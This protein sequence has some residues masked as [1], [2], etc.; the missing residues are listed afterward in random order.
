[1]MTRSKSSL[2]A[3]TF[4]AT[5]ALLASPAWAQ[6][7]PVTEETDV[8]TTE[9]ESDA[10]IVVTGTIIQNP[11]LTSS[12]PVNAVSENELELQQA[13]LAE[14]VLRE[15]PGI[16][17]S[18]GQASN[19]GNGGNSFVDLRGLGPNRNVVLLDGRRVVP[20]T[21]SGLFDLNNIP[22]ALI[23][24]V[25]VLTGGASTT[26]GAD[27]VSGVV[28]F[29]TRRDFAGIDIN[30]SE[31]IS[32]RGDGNIFRADVLIGASFD[33]GRG[34][35]VINTGYQEADPI[36]PGARDFGAFAISSTT[37]GPG[38]SGT[39]VPSRFTLGTIGTR[40]V[41]ATGDAFLP[42]AA[43]TAFNFNPYNVYQVPFERYNVY[44]AGNYQI[45]DAIEV[46]GRGLFSQNTVDTIIAPSG[47]FGIAVT[48]P[49]NNPFLTPALRNQFCAGNGIPQAACD[50]AANP[51]LRPGDA[52]YRQVA[53]GLFRRAVEVG[54]RISNYVNSVFD[55]MVGATGG[56][57]DTID[58]DLFGAYGESRQV[59]EIQNYLL[60]SRTR[61]SIAA[62]RNA[63]GQPVCFQPA[64]Q[65][66]VGTFPTPASCVPINW[67]GPAG[68]ATWT[69]A[70]IDFLSD[71]SVVRTNVAL[72]QARGTVSGDFGWPMPWAEDPVAFA[73]GG[74]YR[75]Y[76]AQQAS[77]SLA[78]SGDLGGAGG[79][80]PNIDGGFHVYEAFAELIVPVIQDRPF[81][82]EVQFE[83]GIRY[84]DYTIDAPGS[85]TFNTT[86]WKV[87][88]HWEPVRG[89]RFRGNY[90]HAVRAPNIAELFAPV[91]T[92]L[93]GL[94]DDPCARLND[95]G[96]PTGRG[97]L[98]GELLAVCLAQGAPAGVVQ[99]ISQPIAGQALQTTGGNINL[100]PETA[101]TWTVGLIFQPD[102]IPGLSLSVDYYNIE[103]TGAVSA[104][105]PNDVI[106]ACFGS[107][108]ANP[109]T[110]V[111]PPAGASTSPACTGIRRDPL[112]GTLSGDPATST[113]LPRQASNLGRI[114]T[115]GVD[116]TL[117]YSRDLGFAG[118]D[119]AAVLNWTDE[120]IFQATPVSAPRE[121]VGFYSVN[122]QQPIF[123]WQWNV[124]TTFSFDD[125]D[126]S[127]L[128]RHFD[129]VRYEPGI[130]TLFAGTLPASTGR[131]AGQ[132]VDFNRIEA[133]DYFDLAI[134]IPVDE[135][136][137]LNLGVQNIF[138]T[139][140]PIVGGEAGDLP[141]SNGNVFPS[142]YDA[143][144][145]FYTA[146]AR[147][148]F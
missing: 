15:V 21:L 50:A 97:P 8:A 68:N 69:P 106:V 39:A 132:Q 20:A 47:S 58:W 81:F 144:G 62:G 135:H 67:F 121:C 23:Q 65:P 64:P 46:Y 52:A 10:P 71:T 93:I 118:L 86:T 6:V 16:V 116:F 32:E 25:D 140:P 3:S 9:E 112:T 84:S 45:S 136:F 27:A 48:L 99:Q 42:T 18:V 111:T 54:P 119:I 26:Y 17:P 120:L 4:F 19:N 130:G 28:N 131:V 122:C 57:T 31:Q 109:A 55:Y 70:A 63:A 128:W 22:L 14:E 94:T 85:P 91:N 141:F 102:F 134:R 37:G 100:L 115:S 44:T 117:N 49:L 89:L 33:D 77:D 145:R 38:G 24:R 88:G 56:I 123:E 124:R 83:G 146:G 29:I 92:G 125:I 12:S 13:N 138:D 78:Q 142:T 143:R 87:G 40:Q 104:P 35:V 137:T 101:N 148:R 72:A 108:A 95:Q 103:I 60:N 79:A 98:T 66:G 80:S 110:L 96:A 107:A 61:A 36:Y 90:S 129:N 127:L 113:G 43:F 82:N 76:D 133:H 30:L 147:I 7:E 51:L 34:T 59:T 11:N 53:T 73:V 114:E 41:N 139:D 126:V 2:L 74:E 5:S 75:E 1:M 105:T